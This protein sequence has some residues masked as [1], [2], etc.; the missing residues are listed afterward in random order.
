MPSFGPMTDE[1]TEEREGRSPAGERFDPP[2][3]AI[4]FDVAGPLSGA[5]VAREIA[6]RSGLDDVS[7][8]RVIRHGGIWIDKHPA[9]PGGL[10]A[11]LA[12]GQSVA[13]YAF[14]REPELA[15]LPATAILLDEDGIVAVDKPAWLPVQGTRA[16]RL[17]SLE[18]LLR[19]R[20]AEPGLR[21]AHRLDRQ[22]SG[23]VL[24]ARDGGVAARLHRSLSK[25]TLERTYLA[26]VMPAPALDELA[27]EGELAPTTT[28]SRWRFE[29]HPAP[30]PGSRSSATRFRVVAREP[31]R[32]LVECIPETGRTHQ[33]RVH[34]ASVGAPIAGDELYGGVTWSQG[35][36]ERVLLHAWKL[37][38]G[39]LP[40]SLEARIPADFPVSLLQSRIAQ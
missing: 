32:A 22:T 38:G 24:F 36:P 11:S 35:G 33:I 13:I 25:H 29:L 23:V 34:L 2:V 10:P 3:S 18:A 5:E 30:V 14:V 4:R 31:S 1:R 9:P 19:E 40:R 17:H 26:V 28:S 15:E 20:L 12:E 27:V 37:G 8:A 39:V 16:S 7:L 6:E 21:A